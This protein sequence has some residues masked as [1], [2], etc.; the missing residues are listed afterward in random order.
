MRRPSLSTIGLGAAL[1]A[2]PVLDGC[3]MHRPGAL[4]V[5]AGEAYELEAD[6]FDTGLYGSKAGAMEETEF[7]AANISAACNGLFQYS[8]EGGYNQENAVG[9]WYFSGVAAGF[10]N[11]ARSY[12]PYDICDLD[13]GEDSTILSCKDSV[14]AAIR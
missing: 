1:V 7:I 14:F 10:E 4:N 9:E 2:S 6:E 8:Y 11:C 5:F 12:I 3:A 13:M